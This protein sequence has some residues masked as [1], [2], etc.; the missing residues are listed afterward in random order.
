MG[1]TQITWHQP[2][3]HL[4]ISQLLEQTSM[5]KW[6]I[7]INYG[8]GS[9]NLK[10][11]LNCEL[12]TTRSRPRVK[13]G[14][15]IQNRTWNLTWIIFNQSKTQS[16]KSHINIINQIHFMN[17]I[18][19]GMQVV[20]TLWHQNEQMHIKSKMIQII[21]TKFMGKQNIQHDH[22]T[23]NSEHWTTLGMVIILYKSRQA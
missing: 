1:T 17:Q 11:K 18:W 14:E 23:K 22:H 20:S 3:K 4:Q 13:N 6:E 8:L 7:I 12:Q 19:Q 2:T 10:S 21:S 5:L 16:K 9:V 15:K